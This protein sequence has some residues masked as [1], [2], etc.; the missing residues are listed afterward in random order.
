[1]KPDAAVVPAAPA[2]AP[3]D[4]VPG[5]ADGPIAGRFDAFS[6]GTAPDADAATTPDWSLERHISRRLLAVVGA[7][8]LAGSAISLGGVWHETSEVLDS[9]LNETAERFLYL[10]E[11]AVQDSR[12]E[13]LFRSEVGPHEE[14]VVYQIFDAAGQLRLR[15]HD[16]PEKPLDPYGANGVRDI[17]GWHVLTLTRTDGRRRVEVAES[18]QHRLE[19]LWG[20]LAWLVGA[21][22][23]V[24]PLAS[25][26]MTYVLRRG[27]ATLEPIRAELARR[28]RDDMGPISGAAAPLEMKPWLATVN[29]LIAG[30][31][32]LIEAERS[33]AARTAHELRT[34]LAAAR[35]QAQRLAEITRDSTAH[36][37]ADALVRQLDR[38]ARLATRLLQLARIE[39][40][41][42]VR[43]EPVD[44]AV[45]GRMVVAE[46]SEAVASERLRI[47]INGE[48]TGV[49][50]DI[51]AI[52]IALR[53]LI[54]N[55][56]KHGGNH[57]WVTV[58]VETLS[59][60]VIND[61]PGVPPEL[62]HK[63][64]R[65]FERGI[66]AAEGSGLGLSIT[67]AIVAQAGGTLE[68]RSP[69]I[70]HN[71]FAAV[72]RFD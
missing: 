49:I 37:N 12:G 24:L 41:A 9:S 71:G 7:L 44:L 23:F 8:W 20:S 5:S 25:I 57:S 45:L 43:R 10:P 1:L 2:A 26:A 34:P 72:L 58:L 29:K 32:V 11:I 64:V 60:M 42:K 39:S 55:A 66:T 21:L 14:H 33:F 3:Q 16:A 46:F 56:L 59:I 40:Q 35:A 47:V 65:P 68:L 28:G 6:L 61:G 31:R 62:L 18:V 19:V 50:G 53:N 52:G 17:G 4:A 70:G 36:Q 69:L 30:D 54:D 15:S 13:R 22:V 67:H 48:T 63:L 51:D 27:F 38:L